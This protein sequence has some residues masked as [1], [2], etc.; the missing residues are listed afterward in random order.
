MVVKT[1][2]DQTVIMISQDSVIT[3]SNSMV[4]KTLNDQTSP[5]NKVN[6]DNGQ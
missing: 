3:I 4:M 6:L 2:K 1:L 5:T